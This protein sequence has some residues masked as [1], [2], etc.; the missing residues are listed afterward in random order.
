MNGQ[1]GQQL[2]L[3]LKVLSADIFC[4]LQLNV[5]PVLDQDCVKLMVFQKD[6]FEKF[7]LERNQQM[8]KNHEK[9]PSI[10]RVVILHCKSGTLLLMVFI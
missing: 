9:M 5:C 2:N 3:Y 7:D 10:Q 4:K 6:I 8:T 1:R